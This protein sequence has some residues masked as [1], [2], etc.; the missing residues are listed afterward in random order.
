MSRRYMG[1]PP[2]DPARAERAKEIASRYAQM[3][4]TARGKDADA[5]SIVGLMDMVCRAHDHAGPDRPL[6]IDRLALSSDVDFLHDIVGM[7]ARFNY[8]TGTFTNCFVP[9][10]G[11]TK[12]TKEEKKDV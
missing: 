3:F 9:R 7:F 1:I 10:C 4:R 11:F 2:P 6:D 5:I 12:K 8:R